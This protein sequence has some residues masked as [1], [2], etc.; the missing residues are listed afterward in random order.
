MVGKL[1]KNE[2]KAGLHSIAPIYVAAVAAVGFMALALAFKI[3]WLTAISLVAVIVIALGILIVTLISVVSNFNKTL[4]RDQGYLSFTLPVTS[5]Q[6]LF[7][8]ALS[9]FVWILLSYIA[10]IG[11]FAG[12]FLY[13]S[14]MV[15]EENIAMIKIL[16]STVAEIPDMGAVIKV[17]TF[18]CVRIFLKIVC[19]IAQIYFAISLSNV[20]PFQKMGFFSTILIFMGTFATTST[21]STLLKAYVPLSL[22]ITLEGAELLFEPMY[23]SSGIVFGFS[24][25]IFMAIASAFF[26]FMTSWFMNHKINLK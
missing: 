20:R 25:V 18:I 8:K 4:F 22:K 15:G 3:A 13:S 14:D 24:D 12:I 11:I 1:I 5:G 17:V 16:V 7:A 2:F 23:N 6:L 19:L 9:S 21:I 10:V 26:F